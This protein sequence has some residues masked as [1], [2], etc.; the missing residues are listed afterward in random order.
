MWNAKGENIFDD[1]W[2]MMRM[3]EII[4]RNYVEDVALVYSGAMKDMN[5]VRKRIAKRK[6]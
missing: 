5:D 4:D 1:L 3:L 2:V 6:K